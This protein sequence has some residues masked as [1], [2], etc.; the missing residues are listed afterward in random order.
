[1][2]IEEY[3]AYFS[4]TKVTFPLAVSWVIFACHYGYGGVINQFLSAPFFIPLA[5]I[6]YVCY[7]IHPVIIF[8]YYYSQEALFHG[9]G[10]TIVNIIKIQQIK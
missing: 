10:L 2:G 5:R 6:S 3:G 7:L 8:A 1:M 9:S 4:L